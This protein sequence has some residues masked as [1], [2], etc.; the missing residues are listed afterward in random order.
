M[1]RGANN[2][3]DIL[4]KTQKE[5]DLIERSCRIVAETLSLIEKYVVPGADTLEIDQIAEDYIRSKGARPA[6]KGYEVEGKFFPNTLCCSINEEIVH[7]IPGSR[8]LNEGDIVSFDCGAE[9]DGYFGDSAVTYAVGKIGQET[10]KLL[11]VTLQALML[12]LEQA[13][14]KNKL[15]D[16]SRAIQEHVE[17]NGFSLTRELVGHGIGKNLHEEPP[18]PNFVPALLH[19]SRYPNVKLKKGMALAIEPMVHM[20]DKEVRSHED[21]WTIITADGSPAAHFEHTVIVDDN[22]PLILTLRD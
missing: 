1:A 13:I 15:Y 22:K 14:D 9:K 19:R 12:G 2:T 4:I 21:G 20:G 18:V 5:I 7:G 8:K 10:Q 3:I 6:F 17:K 16:V 11:D